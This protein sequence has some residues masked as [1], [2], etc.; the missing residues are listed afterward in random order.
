MF[1]LER[2]GS[3]CIQ[4]IDMRSKRLKATEVITLQKKLI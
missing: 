1:Q 3:Q 2:D 4:P